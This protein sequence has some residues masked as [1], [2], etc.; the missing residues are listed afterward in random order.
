MEEIKPNPILEFNV[1]QLQNVRKA[2]GYGDVNKLKQ[3]VQQL[4]EWIKK[5]S[6]F[7]VK[8]FDPEYLERWLIYNKGSIERT[9]Q[10]FDRLCTC[11][12]LMPEFLQNFD[13]KN[14]FKPLF[15]VSNTCVMP[16]PTKDNY[17]LLIT[18]INGQDDNDF[19]LIHYYRYLLVFGHYM[20]CNDYCHG[21]EIIVDSRNVTM[22]TIKELNPIVVHKALTLLIE[23]MGQRIRRLHM[24]S[25]SKLFDTLL[26]LFKQGLS[27]K[28][29]ERLMVHNNVESLHQ[30][31][32]KDQLPQELGGTERP[33]KEITDL[34]FKQLC[35]D[36]H[37]AKLKIME[38]ATTDEA[39]RLPGKFNEEYSGMPG[40]FKTL[41]V[42]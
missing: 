11:T 1:N 14:E 28:L 32:P 30:Y 5:Q 36:E 17:R 35:T 34:N 6:H 19:K 26:M 16:K 21:Y 40:S 8:E 42:D 12:N 23:A 37:I 20:L 22:G 13:V 27:T 10:R 29:K 39:C 4:S 38:A 7:R 41:C 24:I 25:G 33:I 18:H 2:L 9:K 15:N 3:D 31:V